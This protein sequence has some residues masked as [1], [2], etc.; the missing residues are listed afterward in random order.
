MDKLRQMDPD[1]DMLKRFWWNMTGT[2]RNGNPSRFIIA[3]N[4]HSLIHSLTS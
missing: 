1:T 3:F 4:P 2:A